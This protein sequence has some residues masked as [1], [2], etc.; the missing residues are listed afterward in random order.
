MVTLEQ[1][2]KQGIKIDQ[3][4]TIVACENGETQI[5]IEKPNYF[6]SKLENCINEF[7]VSQKC[8]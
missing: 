5:N 8:Y 3:I 1:T 4:V 2:V 7:I 6:V